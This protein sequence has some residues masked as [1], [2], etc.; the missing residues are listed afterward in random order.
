M[1]IRTITGI[2]A[3]FSLLSAAAVYPANAEAAD[4]ASVDVNAAGLNITPHIPSGYE[5]VIVT[6]ADPS[7]AIVARLTSF[8]E[9]LSW[10]PPAAATEG[11]WR[12]EIVAVR[13]APRP[14]SAVM[15][16]QKKTMPIYRTSGKFR[17]RAK[18]VE[19]IPDIRI[20][21]PQANAG[22]QPGVMYL[23]LYS[24]L[25]AVSGVADADDV[26]SSSTVPT[27]WWDDTDGPGT[28]QWNMSAVTGVGQF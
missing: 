1:S 18:A 25:S 7:G 6:V 13:K 21:R 23:A 8:G 26:T 15:G 2:L 5:R 24:M 22:E 11:Q 9:S 27:H 12:Y 17:F 10:S 20:D 16:W 19:K 3:A 14:T 4:V 28:F